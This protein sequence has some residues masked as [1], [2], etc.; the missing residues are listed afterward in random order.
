MCN[1]FKPGTVLGP[2]DKTKSLGC[3]LEGRKD[4]KRLW[5][6]KIRVRK[7]EKAFGCSGKTSMLVTEKSDK[8]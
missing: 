2:G 8:Q 6:K 1:D 3:I 5:K 7:V 4:K